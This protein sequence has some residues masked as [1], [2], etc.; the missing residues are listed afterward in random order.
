MFTVHLFIQ[1]IKSDLD[2][3]QFVIRTLIFAVTNSNYKLCLWFKF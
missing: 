2:Y 1:H 3:K